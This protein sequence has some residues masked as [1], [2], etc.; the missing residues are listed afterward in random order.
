M[1]ETIVRYKGKQVN[2]IKTAWKTCKENAEITR[3]LRPYD[4]RHAFAT[5]AM[6]EGA[7]LKDVADIM[8]HSDVSMV[9]KHYQ[10]GK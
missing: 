9:L 5:Y 4:L 8:G 1:P 3:R 6:D 10:H 2:S 7:D